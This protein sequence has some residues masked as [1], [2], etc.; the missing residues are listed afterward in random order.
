MMVPRDRIELPTRGFSDQ[1][2]ENSKMLK[3]QVVD[4]IP[5][6]R[7]IF[8]FVWNCLEIFDLDGHNL[9]TFSFLEDSG[10]SWL[11]L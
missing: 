2:F 11:K 4:S 6:F 5:I 3:L 9:G 7:R 8:G 1:I 10:R